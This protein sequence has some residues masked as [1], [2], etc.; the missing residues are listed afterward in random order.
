MDDAID[1]AERPS[2]TMPIA[3]PD[4]SSTGTAPTD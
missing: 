2:L 3:V 1:A 4:S